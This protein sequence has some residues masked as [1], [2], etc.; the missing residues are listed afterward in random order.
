MKKTT[1][2]AVALTVA[3]GVLFGAVAADK[4]KYTTEEV[5]KALHKGKESIGKRVSDGNGTKEDFKKLLEYYPSLPLNHPEKG[6]EA[7][8]KEKTTALLK[9][10]QA[11][12]KGAPGALDQYKEAVNCKACHSAHKPDKEH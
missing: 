6:D 3:G 9:A 4:P 12:D 10:A 1:K 5:M 11:L 8:W 2:L 7:S